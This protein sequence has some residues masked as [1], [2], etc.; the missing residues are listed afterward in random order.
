[1]ST[2]GERR[3]Q[4]FYAATIAVLKDIQSRALALPQDERY[5]AAY[6]MT[7]LRK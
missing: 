6:G 4:R 7:L 5:P 1:M 2:I 3:D